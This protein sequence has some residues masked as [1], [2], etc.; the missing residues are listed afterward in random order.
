MRRDWLNLDGAWQFETDRGDSGLERGLLGREL[1]EEIL[2]PFPP[3]SP[4]RHRRHRRAEARA[5]LELAPRLYLPASA[6]TA[7]RVEPARPAPARPAAGTPRCERPGRRQ[8]GELRGP[9]CRLR[10][11]KAVLLNGRRPSSVWSW[12]RG[13]YPDG[14]MTAP[15]D[16]ALVRDI[17]LALAAGFNGARL[18]L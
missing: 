13:W 16:E 9:A 3:E 7:P 1:R 12:T 17:E 18:I 4:V 14:L 8:R 15:T 5:D 10:S 11:G 6:R 2:V